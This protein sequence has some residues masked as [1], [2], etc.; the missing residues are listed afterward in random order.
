MSYTLEGFCADCSKELKAES[1]LDGHE[2][3]R[4]NLEK[5]LGEVDFIA[6]HCGPNAEPGIRTIYKDA[7]TGF[8]VLVHVYEAG[9]T[10]P[11]HDHGTS[12]AV[13]G[14]AAE[15]TDMTVWRRLD[16]GATDGKA[17]LV[18]EQNFRIAPGMAGKFEVGDIHSV[19]FPDGARFVR[20]T[21]TDLDSI[22]TQRFDPDKDV[23]KVG[24]RL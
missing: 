3:V 10:G 5:L 22:P 4:V 23:V 11:P 24:S 16:D 8:T 18:K 15:F 13:Y 12:W 20:V 6:A 7:E 14:Q 2:K 17:E 21:G 9:K 19:H 1:G